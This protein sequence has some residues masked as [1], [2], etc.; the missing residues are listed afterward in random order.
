MFWDW[1]W[2]AGDVPGPSYPAQKSVQRWRPAAR[3]HVHRPLGGLIVGMI[4]RLGAMIS[5]LWHVQNR[6]AGGSRERKGW[7]ENW[8]LE[9]SHSS[10]WPVVCPGLFQTHKSIPALLHFAG[11]GSK[12]AERRVEIGGMLRRGLSRSSCLQDPTP[13]ASPTHTF[14]AWDAAVSRGAQQ[15]STLLVSMSTIKATTTGLFFQEVELV[16]CWAKIYLIF[17]DLFKAAALESWRR[18]RRHN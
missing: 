14:N 11:T 18:S 17:S 2:Q 12:T 8:S 10:V 3:A 16:V 15:E 7:G 4:S 5:L 6:F 9:E 13:T 1:L